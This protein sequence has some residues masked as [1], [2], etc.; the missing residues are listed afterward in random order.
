MMPGEMMGETFNWLRPADLVWRYVVD[1]YMLGKKPKPFDILYW[2]ADQT[3]LPGPTHKTYLNN[4]Y[5]QNE[6]ANGKFKVFGKEVSMS[7]ITI[8]VMMQ[9]GRDDHICPWTSIYRG[10]RNFGGET[11]VV[12]AG[13]GHIAG[14]VNHPAANK[15]QHWV[16]DIDL[17]EKADIWMAGT[18]EIKGSWW[19]TWWDWLEPKS[20][21]KIDPPVIEDKKLGDAPGSYVKM[22]LSDI[23]EGKKPDETYSRTLKAPKKATAKPKPKPKS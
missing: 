2:N 12:L 23:A 19:P 11:R 22:R 10:A 4:L 13:S 17:P 21:A 16:N 18:E 7:D 20:G 15:Y 8:P 5:G 6:L 9:A 3:N 1:N 14:V